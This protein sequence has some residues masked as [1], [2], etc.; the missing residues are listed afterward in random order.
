MLF[1]ISNLIVR[2]EGA[3]I[4]KSISLEV[5]KNEIVTLIG[6]NGAGKTTTL[7]TISGLKNPAS[8]EI[9]FAGKRIDRI[10]PQEI[11]KMGIGHGP[12]GRALFPY[13]SVLENL[14]LGSYLRRDRDGIHKDLEM[15]FEHFPKLRERKYQQ[16]GTL[17]GG[18]Q[19]MLVI[20]RALMGKPR[21][22]MLDEPSL[23]LSPLIIQE[24][25]RVVLEINRGG[26]SVLLVEQNARLALKLAHRG[27]VL[28]TGTVVLQGKTENLLND[29]RVKRA[30]LG[31]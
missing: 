5:Q 18:E 16:A 27:Y 24:I 22:L 11:V 14:R 20:G 3:E 31:Q 10:L 29:V 30:Y 28:E 21:L 1:K 19:Q 7:R 26:T 9:W 17:S 6:S 23:G 13:M 8:G 15:I 12:Q 2:Y 4:L 25:G